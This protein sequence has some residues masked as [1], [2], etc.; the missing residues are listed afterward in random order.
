MTRTIQPIKHGKLV[1]WECC[2]KKWEVILT[3]YYP[4]RYYFAPTCPKC[5]TKGLP[6]LNKQNKDE[7]KGFW[8]K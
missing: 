8:S 1:T 7:S 5:G 6:M 4:D 3:N 2:G